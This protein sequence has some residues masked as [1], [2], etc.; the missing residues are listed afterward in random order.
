MQYRHPDPQTHIRCVFAGVDCSTINENKFMGTVGLVATSHA[1]MS[2]TPEMMIWVA[3]TFNGNHWQDF[4]LWFTLI[5]FLTSRQGL[6]LNFMSDD[7][8]RFVG[9][10]QHY[11]THMSI[12]SYNAAKNIYMKYFT[13]MRTEYDHMTLQRAPGS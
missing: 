4:L 13:I 12:R 5:H 10:V 9:Y 3:K 8:I 1:I 2:L 11:Q 6:P 7:V